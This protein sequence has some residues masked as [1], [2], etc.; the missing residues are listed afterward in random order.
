MKTNNKKLITHNGSFHS[1][2]I[3]AAATL[4]LLLEKN[5]ESFEIIRTRDSEI[6]K[7]GD[8]VF[9]VGGVYDEKNNR[10]DHHQIGGAG[11]HENGIEYSSFGLVWKKFGLELTGSEKA[12][13]LIDKRLVAPIDASDNGFDLV[14]SKHEIFPYFIQDFFLAMNPTWREIDLSKDE[15]FL[16]CV[17]IAKNILTR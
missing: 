14:E 3:F 12:A 1:D 13:E 5:G 11:K 7:K 9:D 4:S 17:E 8:Y 15:M 16:K 2:D 6:I 10:F